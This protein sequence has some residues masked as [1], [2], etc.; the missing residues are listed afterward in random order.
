MS[1]VMIVGMLT[2]M[3]PMPKPIPAA[4]VGNLTGGALPQPATMALAIILHLGYGG[5]WGGALAAVTRRVTIW[6]G[7]ALGV[8]LWLIMQVV[9]LPFLG[10]GLFGSSQTPKIA[11]ATLVLHLVYGA[12]Y[13]WLM[14]RRTAGATESS[15]APDETPA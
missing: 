12:T 1:A 10:W 15:T 2:G 11:V 7:I 9:V 4:I 8:A 13:G 3:S 6:H 14:D 5:F